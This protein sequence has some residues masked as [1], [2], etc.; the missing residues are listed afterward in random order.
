MALNKKIINMDGLKEIFPEMKRQG[1]NLNQIA[2]KLNERQFVDYDQELGSTLK[3]V[4][5]T[6]QSL[7]RFLAMH[8]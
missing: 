7:R 8:Q 2:K 6:W 4:K 1:V 5:E 3:E